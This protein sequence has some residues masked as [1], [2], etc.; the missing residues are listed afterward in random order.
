MEPGCNTG[1]M[2]YHFKDK[3]GGKII[4]ADIDKPAIDVANKF[5]QKPDIFYCIDTVNSDF[6]NGFIDNEIT[7]CILSSHIKHIIH[8]DNFES[9]FKNILRISK[10]I[11]IHEK[12][13]EQII[14]LFQ[15]FN[16]PKEQYTYDNN[17]IFGFIRSENL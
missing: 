4:G 17:Q 2:L 3:L 11:I 6:L 16:I 12:Y 5:V 13:K 1:K 9:Y 15:K 7:L 14:K 8:Y 10:I